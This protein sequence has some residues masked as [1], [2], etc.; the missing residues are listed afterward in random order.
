MVATTA[1]VS[2]QYEQ[3]ARSDGDSGSSEPRGSGDRQHDA[4]GAISEGERI[5]D[6]STG[7]DSTRS[8]V[9]LDE[10]AE[11][12][13]PWEEITLGERIG[14]GIYLCIVP[15][16]SCTSYQYRNIIAD[17]FHRCVI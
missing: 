2:K 6:R 11:C 3:G 8:D 12:E 14:L 13:I 10:V 1:A 7:N 9:G 16:S 15:S 5:S 17:A 4:S